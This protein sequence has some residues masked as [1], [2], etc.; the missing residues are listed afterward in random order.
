[1]LLSRQAIEI[2]FLLKFFN[3]PNENEGGF[4]ELKIRP[5]FD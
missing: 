4:H 5:L 3:N 2:V 1:M